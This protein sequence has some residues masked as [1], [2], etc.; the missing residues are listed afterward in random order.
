MAPVVKELGL[1]GQSLAE[2]L[3]GGDRGTIRKGIHELE[4]GITGVDNYKGRGRRKAEEHWPTLLVDIQS[5]VDSQSQMD[6][7]FNSA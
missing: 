4:S 3:L 6:P 5:I 1:G 2:Q 7:G